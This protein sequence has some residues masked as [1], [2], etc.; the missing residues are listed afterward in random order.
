MKELKT[1]LIIWRTLSILYFVLIFLSVLPVAVLLQV[2]IDEYPMYTKKTIISIVALICSSVVF[3]VITLF[4]RKILIA[5]GSRNNY[6][7]PCK[8]ALFVHNEEDLLLLLTGQIRLDKIAENTYY[9]KENGRRNLRVFIF[10]IQ[11][12]F[13]CN[14][15]SF[16]EPYV[17]KVNKATHFPALI[18]TEMHQELG[19]IQFFLYDEVP[20]AV[21]ELSAK[22]VE[23]CVEQSEFL[24]NLFIDLKEGV[25][26]VPF[27]RSRLLG[28]GRLY[29]Y[30]LDRVTEWLNLDNQSLYL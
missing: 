29:Q 26:Y 2:L 1:D 28:V 4:F 5:K 16:A 21:L 22:R 13:S 18:T 27:C 15:L 3:V 8:I 25:L 11:N 24:I 23:D 20:K 14:D 9:G 12:E 6:K 10:A 17:K 30:A 7:S 19:R